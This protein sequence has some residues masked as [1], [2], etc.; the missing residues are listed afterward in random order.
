[1]AAHVA[2]EKRSPRARHRKRSMKRSL[3]R[4]CA[5]ANR[6]GSTPTSGRAGGAWT[7]IFLLPMLL[8]ASPAV[9][10]EERMA[11][12]A[13]LESDA[14]PRLERLQ[15]S[16]RSV[17]GAVTWTRDFRATDPKKYAKD[18]WT[19][20]V[21][22][23]WVTD[24]A[25]KLIA[26][27]YDKTG[28]WTSRD[29]YAFNPDYAFMAR[30]PVQGGQWII[31]L[32]GRDAATRD[33]V[34]AH[35]RTYAMGLNRP[36]DV[37][38]DA[39]TLAEIFK[40]KDF[41]LISCRDVARGGHE[42]LEVEFTFAP[43]GPGT[44]ADSPASWAKFVFEPGAD[45]RVL[46]SELRAAQWTWTTEISYVPNSPEA[47][48]LFKIVDRGGATDGKAEDTHHV[49]FTSLTFQPTPPGEFYMSALGLP[50]I[51]SE[52]SRRGWR[53]MLIGATVLAAGVLLYLLYRRNQRRRPPG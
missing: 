21:C 22:E 48:R 38:G 31:T 46:S 37:D 34:K 42:L 15:Q 24:S 17:T 49:H 12:R 14:V 29:A 5:H 39:R 35:V 25:G 4:S 6:A 45:W 7:G 51:P 20:K 1:L 2:I 33:R 28:K 23:F 13:R 41:R 47:G 40:G 10:D 16:M 26:D 36:Y 3:S 43:T 9:T 19:R 27:S 8:G 32:H 44:K 18:Y 30:Q 11:C 50:E 52:S 53:L